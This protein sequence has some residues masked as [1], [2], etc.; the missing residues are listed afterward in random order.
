MRIAYIMDASDEIPEDLKQ[1]EEISIV[2]FTVYDETGDLVK[3]LDNDEINEF[4]KKRN[5]GINH[6]IEPTQG[7]YRDLYKKLQHEGFSHI[8]CIPQSKE[9]SKSYSNALYATR[10]C[11]FN[12]EVVDSD[13]LD[14][15]PVEIVEALTVHEYIE[16]EINKMI[17]VDGII[18]IILSAVRNFRYSLHKKRLSSLAR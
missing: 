3:T 17:S 16:E 7:I 5:N 14:I 4:L 2:P 8:I 13:A 12:I 6:I 15:S 10:Y 1:N 18:A 11:D 9:R